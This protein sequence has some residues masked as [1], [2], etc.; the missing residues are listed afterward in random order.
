M[1]NCERVDNNRRTKDSNWQKAS[2][3][4]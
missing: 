1:S 2:G 4:R 3:I